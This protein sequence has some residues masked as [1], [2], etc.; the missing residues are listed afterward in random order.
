MMCGVYAF[1]C[2]YVWYVCAGVQWEVAASSQVKVL[3]FGRT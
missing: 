3:P 1:V 2:M